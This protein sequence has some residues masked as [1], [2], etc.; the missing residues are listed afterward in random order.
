MSLATILYNTERCTHSQESN[1]N[2]TNSLIS[3]SINACK[4]IINNGMCV[5]QNFCYIAEL[6]D[7]NNE[8]SEKWEGMF[9]YH[10]FIRYDI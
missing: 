3:P 9:I 2:D 4:I 5:L 1:G 10:F 6:I 7:W 8:G